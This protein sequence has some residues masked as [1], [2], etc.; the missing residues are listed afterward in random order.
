MMSPTCV[1]RGS[2]A[3]AGLVAQVVQTEAGTVEYADFGE[4]FPVVAIHGA[5][6]GWD[7]SAIL[8]RCAVPSGC[9]VIAISRPG[10]LGTPMVSGETSERQG[11]LVAAL[12]KTLGIEKAAVIAI[13]GGGPC[14]MAFA[15]RYPRRCAGL[16]LI[17]TCSV[18]NTA[19]LPLAY[20]LLKLAVRLPGVFPWMGRRATANPARS[21][22]KAIAD[23]RERR[24]MLDDPERMGLY[25]TL[26]ASNFSRASQRMPGTENDI[27]ITRATELPIEE[28]QSPVLVI[29]GT[30]DRVAP[31]DVH[32]PPFSERIEGAR[33]VAIE[34]GEHVALFTHLDRV[35]SEVAAFLES[36]FASV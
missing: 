20:H 30:A 3:L 10:Y 14:A 12:L 22:A 7:Q 35:R 2:G 31:F 19:K 15:L 8:A 28:I 1:N 17:S 33:I 32:V 6:G 24:R 34:G 21:L 11:D 27:F 9:R 25:L 4:G 26:L 5:L 13:S 23:P 18:R 16:V 36:I 29:H